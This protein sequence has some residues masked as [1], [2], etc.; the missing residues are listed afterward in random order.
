MKPYEQNKQM[1]IKL[2]KK[3]KGTIGVPYGEKRTRKAL[4]HLPKAL[5]TS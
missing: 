2:V 4:Q 3:W 5:K 1:N